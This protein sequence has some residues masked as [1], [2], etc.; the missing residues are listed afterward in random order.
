VGTALCVDYAVQQHAELAV[1]GTGT[2]TVYLTYARPNYSAA[3]PFRG[4]LD[5]VGVNLQL[6][7]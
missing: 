2:S 7:A 5:V 4:D 3:T 6:G 1:N